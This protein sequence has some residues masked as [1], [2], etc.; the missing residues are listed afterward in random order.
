MEFI[1]LPRPGMETADLQSRFFTFTSC[2][3]QSQFLKP[4]ACVQEQKME[5]V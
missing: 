3:K 5:S 4:H 2:Q 1:L